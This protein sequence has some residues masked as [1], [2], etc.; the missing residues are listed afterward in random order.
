[1]RI[2]AKPAAAAARSTFIAAAPATSDSLPGNARRVQAPPTYAIQPTR[3]I[4]VPM[5]ARGRLWPGIME[6][7]PSRLIFPSGGP[8]NTPAT[9]ANTPADPCRADAP[10]R[11]TN[12][13]RL[14]HPAHAHSPVT[15]NTKPANT[16]DAI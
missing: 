10:A 4:S 2:A 3:V 1:M 16:S 14:S 7:D 8:T 9:P 12:P 13:R 15:G 5:A 6:E 11:S